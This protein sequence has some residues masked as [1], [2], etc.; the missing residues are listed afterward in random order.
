MTLA[1]AKKIIFKL[2]LKKRLQLADEI[3]DSVPDLPGSVGIEELERRIDEVES[4]KVKPISWEEFQRDLDKMRKSIK[5]AR[6]SAASPRD[7][8]TPK[9]KPRHSI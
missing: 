4:G 7:R 2:P 8:K 3:Y 9:S 6:A 1:T 5:G